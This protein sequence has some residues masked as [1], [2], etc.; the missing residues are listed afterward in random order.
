MNW[1]PEVVRVEM[2]YRIERATGLPHD[3]TTLEHLR[4]AQHAHRSWWRR[5]RDHHP[6]HDQTEGSRAA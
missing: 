2:D 5:H 3:G 6:H 4:A 1:A